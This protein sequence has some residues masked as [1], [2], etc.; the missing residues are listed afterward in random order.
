MEKM[1]IGHR[2]RAGVVIA[3]VCLAVVAACTYTPPTLPEVPPQVAPSLDASTQARADG[4]APPDRTPPPDRAAPPDVGPVGP[5][6]GPPPPAPADAGLP[7][8][9]DAAL[10]D[11]APACVPRA[12]VCN[13]ADDNCDG[14]T[15][16]GCPV[17]NALLVTQGPLVSSPV[18]G[19]LNLDQSVPVVHRCPP[20]QVVVA[21][22]GNSG[23]AIDSLGVVCA[24]LRVRE[25]SRRDALSL[26]PRVRD[27]PHLPAGRRHQRR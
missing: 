19:S 21:I 27:G 22:T 1:N 23:Y 7:S 12:E 16:D 18:F 4:G 8:A 20:G 3:A 10:P 5:I 24:A 26:S 2:D 17:D 25:D 9:P 15:D 11:A 14:V 6:D 13:G